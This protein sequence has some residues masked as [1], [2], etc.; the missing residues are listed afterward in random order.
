MITHANIWDFLKQK[1]IKI[2]GDLVEKRQINTISRILRYVKKQSIYIV[3]SLIA[4]TVMVVATLYFP[5]LTGNAIDKIVGKGNVDFNSL[6]II[7][8]NMVLVLVVI[9]IS[10][11]IMNIANNRLVYMT[12][13]SIRIDAFNKLQRVP[14]KTIDGIAHG[15]LVTRVV[16]DVDQFADGLLMGFTQ[17]FTSIMTIIGTLIFMLTI[18]PVVALVVIVW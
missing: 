18:H 16:A 1:M 14:I 5:I 12:V 7:L 3:L 17:F 9:A 6:G 11:W 15:D 8:K 4:A 2:G 13:K 10:N